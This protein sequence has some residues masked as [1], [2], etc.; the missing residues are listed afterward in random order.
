MFILIH[1]IEIINTILGSS[2]SLSSHKV[3]SSSI[4]Y[5]SLQNFTKVTSQVD[6]LLHKMSSSAKSSDNQ[7][8][9]KADVLEVKISIR[10]NE[11]DKEVPVKICEC[12]FS[13]LNKLFVLNFCLF[14]TVETPKPGL[15]RSSSSTDDEQQH[16]SKISRRQLKLMFDTPTGRTSTKYL[17]TKD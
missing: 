11:Y 1:S 6:L 15:D 14:F 4:A 10:N 7:S 3:E 16:R 13:V 5:I 12:W 9:T 2:N 8:D 17:S